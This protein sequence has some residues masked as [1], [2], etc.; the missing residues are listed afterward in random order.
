MS[1][2]T[3]SPPQ[4]PVC[5]TRSYVSRDIKG[6][7]VVAEEVLDLEVHL[8]RLLDPDDYRCVVTP[9]RRCNGGRMHAH[10]L[11]ERLLLPGARE[12]PV[13][14]VTIRLFRC[15]EDSCRAVFTVLPAFI[16]RHLWRSWKTVDDVLRRDRP[17][18]ATTKR[19]WRARCLSDA[20]RLVQSFMSLAL[21]PVREAL[22]REKPLTRSSFVEALKRFV[23][24]PESLFALTASWI[25]R[26]EP[27]IRL[28]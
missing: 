17:A 3:L 28:M 26:L 4:A 13:E 5:L 14:R 23:S 8:S 9:C 10:S 15:A 11:R 27:G 24:S 2:G 7:T 19:R 22:S 16:A 6:G 1:A 18:P 12:A 20:T 21:P 25:H